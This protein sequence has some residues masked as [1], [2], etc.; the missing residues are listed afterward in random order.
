MRDSFTRGVI[1]AERV[2]RNHLLRTDP[3][4][5]KMEL[6]SVGKMRIAHLI[7]CRDRAVID[8][9]EAITSLIQGETSAVNVQK[10]YQPEPRLAVRKFLDRLFGQTHRLEPREVL[11]KAK[12]ALK[13]LNTFVGI[14]SALVTVSGKLYGLRSVTK[15][16][17][18]V[19]RLKRTGLCGFLVFRYA[20]TGK[21]GATGVVCK[22]RL[23]GATECELRRR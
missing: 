12:R 14:Q 1:E 22:I 21:M 15:S 19:A 4:I 13:I 6:T 2:S 3:S 18:T 20:I 5:A 9:M 8:Q 23:A 7:M 11:T 16:F 10:I 17:E